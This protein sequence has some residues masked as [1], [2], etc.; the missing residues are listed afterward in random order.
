M[1]PEFSTFINAINPLSEEVLEE[2]LQHFQA[3]EYPKNYVLLRQGK[4]CSHLWFL[5]KGAVRYFYSDEEGKDHNVWFSMDRDILTDTP[6][7]LHEK[8]AEAS[9][10]LLEDCTLWA[11]E[12]KSIDALLLKHHSFALWYIKLFEQFYVNQIEDRIVDLQFLTARQRYEKLLIQFP[13]IGQRISLG[14]IA[15]YLN[16]TQETLSRIRAGKS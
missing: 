11:I 6:S 4:V 14:H 10:Q 12:R 16:I 15:S 9:I 13:D 5:T 2:V 8:P 7:F 3:M 1:N